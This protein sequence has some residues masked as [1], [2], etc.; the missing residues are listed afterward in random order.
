MYNDIVQDKKKCPSCHQEVTFHEKSCPFC[1][2]IFDKW[3]QHQTRRSIESENLEK[4]K[5]TDGLVIKQHIELA[6]ILLNFETRNS[7]LIKDALGKNLYD[8]EEISSF[9]IRYILGSWRPLKLCIYAPHKH[10]VLYLIKCFRLYFHRM[11]VYVAGGRYLGCIKKHFMFFG[12]WYSI[13]DAQGTELFE[14][15][16]PWWHPWTFRIQQ[17]TVEIGKI[18]KRWVG[19]LKEGFTD[20]DN[21]GVTFPQQ[22]SN[23]EKSLIL[24]ATMLIDLIHFEK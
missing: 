15:Y 21:F 12:R 4:L 18:V 19:L 3:E 17:N 6:E 16:G 2:I 9:I 14:I 13:Y 11:D 1:S 8:A 20:I 5:S 10:L 22:L 23:D 24:G 7:Y